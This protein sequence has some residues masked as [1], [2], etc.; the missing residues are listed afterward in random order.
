MLTLPVYSLKGIYYLHTRVDGRQFKRSL[1]TRDPLLA[2]LRAVELL[3]AIEM[4][5]PK[6]SDF[7][8]NS[9]AIKRYEIELAG[10]RIKATDEAD[11]IRA[12]EAIKALSTLHNTPHTPKGAMLLKDDGLGPVQAPAKAGLR[13]S[14]VLDKMIDLRTNLKQATVISYKNTVKE[15]SQYTKA[16]YITD[17]GV[18][19][20]TRYQEHLSAKKNTLRTIDNKIAT[21]RALFN[22]AI[23]QGYYFA[24][25]PAQDRQLLTKRD[26][27]KSGYAIFTIEEIKS[28]YGADFLKTQRTKSPDYYWVLVIA[29]LSGCR[30][31]E[32]TSLTREQIKI[33]P[34]FV[35]LNIQD[36]KTMAGIREVPIP[37]EVL[38]FGFLD[39][40]KDRSG[41]I[42]KY[43]QREGKGSGN[44]AG[45]MFRRHLDSIK[46][47]NSKLVFHS[48]RKFTNDYFQKSGVDFEPRCQFFGHE[49]D[50]VNLNFYTNKFTA[51][52]LF[53][54][55]Q[56]IQMQLFEIAAQ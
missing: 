8:V 20:I 48:L 56:K 11:H 19:D 4:T 42:F 30:V 46:I 18:G 22:F 50:N 39:F 43:S 35:I 26:K 21:L 3:R 5:K 34:S 38:N 36:S 37:I 31:G 49:V 10:I 12:L 2:R 32:I 41:V 53:K 52:E 14:E 44:A 23:K 55:T 51:G 7:N 54:L 9:E 25:N 6:L 13:I 1:K 29:L 47:G 33:T 28:I 24:K 40:I 45:K 15:F 16:P 17:L 27:I